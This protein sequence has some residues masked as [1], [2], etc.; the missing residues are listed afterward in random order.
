MEN[1]G[2]QNKQSTNG[3]HHACYDSNSRL[4]LRQP[5][6]DSRDPCFPQ[7]LAR[8]DVLCH[9][10]SITQIRRLPSPPSTL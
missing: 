6:Q 8:I 7:S 2:L 3:G 5:R 1:H 4:Q 10:I 9:S